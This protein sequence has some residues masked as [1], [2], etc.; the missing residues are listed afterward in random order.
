MNPETQLCVL[1]GFDGDCGVI[2]HATEQWGSAPVRVVP[3]FIFGVSDM[4]SLLHTS[5]SFGI[6][7]TDTSFFRIPKFCAK[8]HQFL[9]ELEST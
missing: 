7:Y 2:I 6:R 1:S 3:C 8:V 5:G 4:C 9:S